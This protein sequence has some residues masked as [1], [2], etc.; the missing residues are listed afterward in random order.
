[1]AV[2]AEPKEA[3]VTTVDLLERIEA[4]TREL[5]ELRR[6]VMRLGG[7]HCAPEVEPTAS[8]KSIVEELWGA[9]GHGS[10]DEYDEYSYWEL[11]VDEPASR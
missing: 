3:T 9:A 5:G 7:R 4:I 11:Y 1:M 10:M 6:D 2:A 8:G